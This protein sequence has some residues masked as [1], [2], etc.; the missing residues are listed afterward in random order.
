MLRAHKQIL[1]LA[2][3]QNLEDSMLVI[4]IALSYLL[5]QT[6]PISM[7]KNLDIRR[8]SSMFQHNFIFSRLLHN[9]NWLQA[10]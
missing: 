6:L 5:L 1:N 10:P 4:G 8:I 7:K 9:D 2:L 3:P